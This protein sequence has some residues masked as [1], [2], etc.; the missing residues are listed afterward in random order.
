MENIRSPLVMDEGVD[1]GVID[2]DR[3]DA[4]LRN[5][6]SHVP[7]PRALE[8]EFGANT[9]RDGAFD[10][11]RAPG[12]PPMRHPGTLQDDRKG[13]GD[14]SGASVRHKWVP[15]LTQYVVIGIGFCMVIDY[16]MSLM[17]IQALWYILEG[18]VNSLGLYGFA[19]GAYDLTQCLFAPLIGIAADRYPLKWV[20][21]VTVL[22]NV[23]GACGVHLRACCTCVESAHGCMY[24]CSSARC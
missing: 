15:T 9:N 17:S 13:G 21:L 10:G 3:P 18:K 22:I 24:V 20:F 11:A 19:F 4:M 8:G 23:G 6:H 1:R 7:P 2:Y 14:S 12:V 5:S 16:T